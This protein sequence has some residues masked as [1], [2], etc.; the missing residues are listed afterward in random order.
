M[1][2][3]D[4]A[5]IADGKPPKLVRTTPGSDPLRAVGARAKPAAVYAV[6]GAA[7][8]EWTAKGL[9][10]K[11]TGGSAAYVVESR[12]HGDE[13]MIGGEAASALLKQT[14][15]KTSVKF[16]G[17]T[18]AVRAIAFHPKG[19][20][21]ALG[22]CTFDMKGKIVKKNAVNGLVASLA[23]GKRLLTA[24]PSGPLRIVDW[25]GK[26]LA[27]LE[28][29][30]RDEDGSV[31]SLAAS[32]VGEAFACTA[33]CAGDKGLLLWNGPERP[34]RALAGM[35]SR[36]TFAFSPDGARIVAGDVEGL[37][38]V[39]DVKSGKPTHEA[40]F[41]HFGGKHVAFVAPSVVAV[42]ARGSEL[43]LWNLERDV[44]VALYA[45]SATEWLALSSDGRFDGTKKM[46][47]RVV[48]QGTPT[49]GL[50]TEWFR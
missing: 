32:P 10:A 7:I 45:T 4:L 39:Y 41:F 36:A 12:P 47:S 8:E 3:F 21:V 30:D 17:T 14:T 48:Q 44:W 9:I 33:E 49:A 28:I 20:R 25:N 13:I 5:G 23:D 6:R 24:D 26:E 35:S 18:R 34:P 46:L 38:R 15:G 2:F 1:S 50:L 37:V 40:S 29:P 42:I 11:A 43:R 31:K 19:D 16:K 27:Q 22:C